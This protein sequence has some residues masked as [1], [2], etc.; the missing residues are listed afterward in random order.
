M[1]YLLQLIFFLACPHLLVAQNDRATGWAISATLSPSLDRRVNVPAL[2]EQQDGVSSPLAG[3]RGVDTIFVGGARRVFDGT[4]Y[5]VSHEPAERSFWFGATARA[6]RRFASGFDVSAGV[7]F[8]A[9]TYAGTNPAT[10]PGV[11]SDTDYLYSIDRVRERQLGGVALVSY[12]LF[13][14]RRL[15]PYFGFG[16]SVLAAHTQRDYRGRYYTG[17]G[18]ILDGPRPDARFLENTIISYDYLANAGL[19]YALTDRW[20][21]ALEVTS[22]PGRAPGLLGLQLR[23]RLGGSAARR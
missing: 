4:R 6:H 10:H 20:A 7:H 14:R 16:L 22:F 18:E 13:S 5:P 1:R 8:G 19:L 12:H 3:R 21:V 23:R 11:D 15:H 2:V 9:A 17:T